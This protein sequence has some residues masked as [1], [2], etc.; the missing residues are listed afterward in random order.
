MILFLTVTLIAVLL[1]F[2]VTITNVYLFERRRK[3]THLLGCGG[4]KHPLTAKEI[5]AIEE[6]IA[7]RPKD[8]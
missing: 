4:S 7:D 3:R 6:R 2:V 1:I 5:R 8:K